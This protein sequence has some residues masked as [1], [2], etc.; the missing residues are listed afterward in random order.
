MRAL[1]QSMVQTSRADLLALQARIEQR[2]LPAISDLAHRI[3]GPAQMI[4]A[5][6]IVECCEALER[7]SRSETPSFDTVEDSFRQL[8]EALQAL[9]SSV[10]N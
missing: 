6:T 5:S 9:E 1:V 3:K 2:D 4:A 7:E 8:R 10:G